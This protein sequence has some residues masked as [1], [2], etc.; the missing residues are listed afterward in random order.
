MNKLLVAASLHING[1]DTMQRIIKNWILK[2]FE[3]D[4]LIVEVLDSRF[5]RKLRL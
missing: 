2:L 1:H 3:F 5:A 4:Y